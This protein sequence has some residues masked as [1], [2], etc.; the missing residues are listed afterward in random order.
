MKKVRIILIIVILII[1]NIFLLGYIFKKENIDLLDGFNKYK[2]V[3][4][5]QKYAKDFT[6]DERGNIYIAYSDKIQLIDSDGKSKLL[7]VGSKKNITALAYYNNFIYYTAENS[8]FRNSIKEKKQTEIMNDLP[9]YGD[10]NESKLMIKDDNLY[11]SIGAATNSGIVGSDNSFTKENP[12][13]HDFSPFTIAINSENTGKFKTGA[14]MPLNT[15]NIINQ[16]IPAQFP[17]N[18]SIISYNIKTGQRKTFAW[19]LRN[20]TGM[21]FNSKGKIYA[22]VGGMENRGVRPIIGDSDYIFEIENNKWYGFPDYSGGDPITSPKFKGKN[23]ETIQFILTNPPSTNPPAPFYQ[24]KSLSSLKNVFIDKNGDWGTKD[25]IYFYD[26]KDNIVY[27]IEN[28]GVLKKK[29][30]FEKNINIVSIKKNNNNLMMLDN[31]TGNIISFNNEKNETGDVVKSLE[32]YGIVF[33]MLI[34]I[35]LI[36][37]YKK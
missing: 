30:K 19:G 25:S 33:L 29:I 11:I 8:L 1:G 22:S 5:V 32:V 10:Y 15:K 31:K 14:F 36:W 35:I 12:L 20:I 3:W 6:Y 9:N 13:F 34:C 27:T 24:H 26:D 28:N 18:S 4:K 16:N 37:K 17:G 23:N 21:D 2:I 7:L